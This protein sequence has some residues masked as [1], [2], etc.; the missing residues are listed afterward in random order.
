M[1]LNLSLAYI[2][3]MRDILQYYIYNLNLV[4]PSGCLRTIIN[5][6]PHKSQFHNFNRPV[7]CKW[8]SWFEQNLAIRFT[9]PRFK[10]YLAP[11]TPSWFRSQKNTCN[12]RSH[13]RPNWFAWFGWIYISTPKIFVK[14]LLLRP[15]WVWWNW[16]S[17]FWNW[18]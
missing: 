2:L 14:C 18:T 10:R 1:L 6:I 5:H 7:F 12:I 8:I 16:W 17:W 15:G 13:F 11:D 9:C 3:L 4:H